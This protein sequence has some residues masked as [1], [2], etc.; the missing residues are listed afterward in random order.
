M[1]QQAPTGF[2][3]LSDQVAFAYL[4]GFVPAWASPDPAVLMQQQ[5]VNGGGITQPQSSTQPQAQTMPEPEPTQPVVIKADGVLRAMAIIQPKPKT[6]KVTLEVRLVAKK[7]DQEGLVHY[8][9]IKPGEYQKWD[10]VEMDPTLRPNQD[11]RVWRQGQCIADAKIKDIN[12]GIMT[13]YVVSENYL[14][15]GDSIQSTEA[16]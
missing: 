3:A 11:V 7:I 4:R 1:V 15:V 5:M 2:E 8:F 12:Q 6:V 10:C 14:Q 16:N 13:V 9:L